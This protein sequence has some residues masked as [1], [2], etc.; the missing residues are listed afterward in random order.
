MLKCRDIVHQGSDYAD[1]S[2][3]WQRTFSYGVH[4]LMCG[5]CRTFVRHLRTTISFTRALPDKDTLSAEQINTI[6]S[7]ATATQERKP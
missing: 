2:M 6:V 3:T 5:H 4:L 7:H 1:G